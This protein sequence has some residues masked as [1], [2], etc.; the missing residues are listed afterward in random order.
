MAIS[1]VELFS[2][3]L[4]NQQSCWSW[5]NVGSCE[6]D[7]GCLEAVHCRVEVICNKKQSALGRHPSS[8]WDWSCP[9]ATALHSLTVQYSDVAYI[10]LDIVLCTRHKI[11]RLMIFCSTG[12][13]VFYHSANIHLYSLSKYY[14]WAYIIFA[15]LAIFKEMNIYF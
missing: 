15:S 13:N 4:R 5:V 2:F 11:S 7:W 9:V 14:S 12:F 3:I 6:A 1:C 10:L 8:P